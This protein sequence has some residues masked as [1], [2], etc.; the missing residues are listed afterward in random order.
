MKLDDLFA[1][2]PGGHQAMAEWVIVPLFLVALGV[3]FNPLDPLWTRSSFPWSWLGPVLVALRYGPFAGLSGALLLLVSWWLLQ[4]LGF[5]QGEIP[6]GFFLGGLMVTM[7]CGEFSSLW[8][9]RV[10]RAEAMQTYLDQ[11][12]DYLTHQHYLLRLSHD[13]LEQDLIARPVSMRDALTDLRTLTVQAPPEER[14]PNAD[15]LLRLLSQFCQIEAAALCHLRDDDLDPEPVARIGRHFELD[16]EDPLVRF[17]IEENRLAHVQLT[18]AR[19][20]APAHYVVAVPLSTRLGE[21]FGLLVVER[22]PFFA[23]HDEMLQ[24]LNLMLGYYADGLDA[25]VTARPVLEAVP[26]CPLPFAFELVR[27]WRIRRDS[28]VGS[29]V[30]ALSFERQP[31]QEDLPQQIQR[32]QRSVDVT[33]LIEHATATVLVTLMPLGSRS[34][35]EG[36]LARIESWLRQQR[37]RQ[38]REAGIS[39]YILTIDDTDPVA[40]M[41][42]LKLACDVPDAAWSTRP[43][44]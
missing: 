30:V 23:L 2:P 9:T 4:Q 18:G 33:W 39:D 36:Y 5:G 24:T 25:R 10:R 13:R 40:V 26:R 42:R 38:L 19:E 32:Q 35:A 7:L 17:A 8:R 37:N 29:I 20:T 41:K 15:P 12:L 14:L 3:W 22:V 34:S 6:L 27:V 16:P 43:S 31:G 21:R 28:G 11:R 1:P 44:T